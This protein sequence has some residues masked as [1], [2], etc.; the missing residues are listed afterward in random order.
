MSD[1]I[2]D[3][4]RANGNRF[5]HEAIRERLVAAGHDGV[6]VDRYWEAIQLE[7]SGFVDLDPGAARSRSDRR[8]IFGVGG[9]S[10]SG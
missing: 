3:Y 4:I 9:S 1:P 6:E 8:R 7:R 10:C 5:T 2:E